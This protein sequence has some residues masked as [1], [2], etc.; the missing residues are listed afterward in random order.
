MLWTHVS[1]T[2]PPFEG[3]ATVGLPVPC[4]YDLSLAATKYFDALEGGDL[5]LCFLFSGTIFFEAGDG[6]L[7]V[8][9]IS[10]EKEATFRL[11]AATW[12]E[13]MD[14]YYPNTAWLS[15][16]KD[17]FDR[18]DRYRRDNGLPTW[19]RALERLLASP[20]EAVLP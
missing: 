5:P 16:R 9:Q 7:Q 1:A 17:V 14:L 13:L 8:A 12:R 15:L 18:L 11:P 6:G 20:E 10:W 2:L 4:T 19:E 3:A